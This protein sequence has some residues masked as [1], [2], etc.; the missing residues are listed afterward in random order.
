MF[1]QLF[2]HPG[3]IQRHRT[4]PLV[5]LRLVWLEDCSRRGLSRSRLRHIA[6]H[7]FRA[8]QLLSLTNESRITSD[9][10]QAAAGRWKHCSHPHC[11]LKHAR[12]VRRSFVRE[13]TKWLT[14]VGL[15]QPPLKLCHGYEDL[16]AEFADYQDR[17]RGIAPSTL[18]HLFWRANDFLGLLHKDRQSLE[19][20]TVSQI[21]TLLARKGREQG[22]GRGSLQSYASALRVF[23]RYTEMRKLSPQGLADQIS[24]PRIWK[25]ESLPAAPSWD[26]VQRLLAQVERN[27]PTAIRD[28]AIILLLSVYGLRSCEVRKLRLEDLD[29]DREVIILHR[30]KLGPRQELPLAPTVGNAVVRYLREVRPRVTWREMF[31]SLHPPY[32]PLSNGAVYHIVGPRLK[33]LGVGL[34]HHGPHA[35]RHACAT[36]LLAQGC[37]LKEIGD[38]LGHSHPDSTRIYAKVDLLLLREVANLELGG[39]L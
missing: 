2:T 5:E 31:L 17:E 34:K 35:L 18:R 39:L 9:Q 28:R 32:R 38:Y 21:D 29:W 8:C 6:L 25:D 24:I 13:V 36:R 3:I 16:V 33:S 4:G 30:S 22:Y 11:N 37:S 19:Q 15:F 1:Q 14:F 10:I 27:H 23:L 26:D 7:L 12:T 20:L